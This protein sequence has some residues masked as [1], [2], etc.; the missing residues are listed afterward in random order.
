MINSNSAQSDEQ[1]WSCTAGHAEVRRG[2]RLIPC[3]RSMRYADL[4][5]G[6]VSLPHRTLTGSAVVVGPYVRLCA[7]SVQRRPAVSGE[8]VQGRGEDQPDRGA[9]AGHH[10]RQDH[11]GASLVVRGRVGGTGA[12]GAGRAPRLP[13]LLRLDDGQAAGPQG[14]TAPVEVPEGQP[15]VVPAYPQRLQLAPQWRAL[16]GQGRRHAGALVPRPARRPEFGHDHPGARRPLLRQLRSRGRTDTVARCGAGGRGRSGYRPAGHGRIHLGQARRRGEPPAYGPEATQARSPG[17]G[18]SPPYQRRVQ[19]GQDATECRCAAWQGVS[20]SAGLSPQAGT[21][22]GAR[23]PSAVCR[24]PEHRGHGPESPV[25]AGDPRRWLAPVRPT[26]AGEG[27]AVRAHRGDGVSL[28]A[29]VEDVF[30]LR[31]RHGHH[32][33]ARPRVELPRL[34]GGARSGSQRRQEHPRRRAGGEA[35]RLWSPGKSSL[36]E[37]TG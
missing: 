33:A 27:R 17:T 10:P 7:G 20:C 21:L 18:K 3:D 19:Q 9:A 5:A 2:P 11:R 29:L 24:G 15:T 25:G 23:E 1:Q 14:R 37:G 22:A 31:A 6:Q 8:G 35:K 13:E 12:V 26:G 30:G 28:A 36:S 16:P 34:R 4:R 32:A